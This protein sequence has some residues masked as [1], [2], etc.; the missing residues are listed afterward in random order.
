M[1]FG[2]ASSRNVPRTGSSGR[3]A[4]AAEVRLAA[5]VGG[6]GA[7]ARWLRPAAGAA[8]ARQAGR[9]SRG[10]PPVTCI[11]GVGTGAEV[12]CGELPADVQVPARQPSQR[13]GTLQTCRERRA[14]PKHTLH[15]YRT[16]SGLWGR[17]Y[18]M[19]VRNCVALGGQD[20]GS[21]G[22]EPVPESTQ[23]PLARPRH[24]DDAVVLGCCKVCPA[25]FTALLKEAPLC[26]QPEC[27]K[28]RR[29]LSTVSC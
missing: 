18:S 29:A 9:L 26:R 17:Y 10:L 24:G 11:S 12:W 20:H 3:T 19:P 16:R 2:G 4:A 6:S 14:P 13:R 23:P 28:G 25:Q 5:V 7:A 15:T 8:G 21:G 27:R 22:H 1:A